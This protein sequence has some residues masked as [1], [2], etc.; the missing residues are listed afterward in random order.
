MVPDE[1]SVADWI[2]REILP[3]ERALREWLQHRF[4]AVRDVED[5]V[6]ECYCRLAEFEDVT[7]ILN[8]RA[9]LFT[10]A[11][12]LAR[13]QLKRASVVRLEPLTAANGYELAGSDPL[14]DQILAS[15]QDLD[16]LQAALAALSERAR[17]IFVMRK[18][19]GLSQKQI[20]EQLG[21]TERVVEND[22]SR[23]LR[24]VLDTITRPD[25]M[26]Q[27]TPKTGTRRD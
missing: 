26:M 22:A 2:G 1:E 27:L 6:Q 18:V 19:E 10:M 7:R 11:R 25:E 23:S 9:Y 16:R 21:V 8:P 5:I 13:H 12:N 14:P 24:A 17:R 15:K 3:H 4:I 20:A